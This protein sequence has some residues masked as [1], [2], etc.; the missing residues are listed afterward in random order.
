[1][2][3]DGGVKGICDISDSKSVKDDIFIILFDYT[4]FDS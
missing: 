1:M 4:L 3:G 2:S